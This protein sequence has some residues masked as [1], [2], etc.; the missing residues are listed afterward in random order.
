MRTIKSIVVHHSVTPLSVSL[1]KS[2]QSFDRNHAER[3]HP[4][5]NSLGFHIAY[6]YVIWAD[7]RFKKT[8]GLDEVWYH[9]SEL[10]VNNTSVGICFCGNFD[11][12]KPTVDQIKTFN[13]LRSELENL[14]WGLELFFHNEFASKSCPWANLTKE[15]L[16]A[17]ETE[18][19][20]LVKEGI[21]SGERPHETATRLE[22]A[23]MLERMSHRMAMENINT[24]QEKLDRENIPDW[25]L[26]DPTVQRVDDL[27]SLSEL[28]SK[29]KNCQSNYFSIVGKDKDK[30]LNQDEFMKQSSYC[31]MYAHFQQAMHYGI[32]FTEAQRKKMIERMIKYWPLTAKGGAS[33]VDVSTFWADCLKDTGA[34]KWKVESYAFETWGN[35]MRRL[36]AYQNHCFVSSFVI[37]KNFADDRRDNEII[38]WLT[39]WGTL[40][41]G[42]AIAYARMGQNNIWMVNSYAG[43]E[44][45]H[46]IIPKSNRHNWFTKKKWDGKPY[47][48]DTS[49]L[50]IYN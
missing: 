19:R 22:V 14:Y 20:S 48:R 46:C 27:M 49:I 18:W 32:E 7:W 26:G 25:A 9:A 21:W 11:I 4:E 13:Y 38:D 45:N 40:S 42:H 6:H 8:R 34:Y 12:E 36:I 29:F 3:L 41:G 16:Q 28:K 15:M 17:T 2:V 37:S 5:L 47:V 50:H 23:I 33:T 10:G 31:T 24:G 1:E 44:I 30:Q 35:M 39:H 43:R